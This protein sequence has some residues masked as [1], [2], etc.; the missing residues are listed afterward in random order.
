M[1]RRHWWY[2]GGAVL[3]TGVI[4]G[5]V[6]WPSPKV[7]PHDPPTRS[8]VYNAFTIC[9]LTGPQ[10]VAG[11]DAAPLWAGVREA[12]NGADD[13]SQYLAAVAS[14]ETVGSVTPFANT[15]IQQRCGLVI[16]VGAVEVSTLES[17]APGNPGTRFM[18]VGGGSASAN[19][20]VVADS[21]MASVAAAVE[22]AVPSN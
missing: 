12:A 17:L 14:P 7:A 16:A 13:Q 19:M 21:S 3:V 18:V 8:R 10:G 15:L 11:G 5:V 6:A 20:Q 1:A 4:V 9:L 22:A 2:G